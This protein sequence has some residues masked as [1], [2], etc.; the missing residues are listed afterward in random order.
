MTIVHIIFYLAINILIILSLKPTPFSRV[1]MHVLFSIDD[2]Y[3]ETFFGVLMNLN[4]GIGEIHWS[5]G[6]IGYHG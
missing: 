5:K 1:C 3:V 6:I 2:N 4:N